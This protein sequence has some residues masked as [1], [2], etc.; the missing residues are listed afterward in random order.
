MKGMGNN[1]L[2]RGVALGGLLLLGGVLSGCGDEA[3]EEEAVE[4]CMLKRLAERCDSPNSTES[5]RK[6]VQQWRDVGSSGKADAC[7]ALI[8]S[9]DNGCSGLSLDYDEQDAIVD[10]AK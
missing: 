1:R 5:L 8:E 4:C 3:E 10:C 9:K 6:S 7:K 2:G